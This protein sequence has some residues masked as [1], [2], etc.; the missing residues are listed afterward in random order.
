M[1][2]FLLIVS[3][4]IFFAGVFLTAVG[5]TKTEE[6]ADSTA[7]KNHSVLL[8]KTDQKDFLK[9]EVVADRGKVTDS[10][11]LYLPDYASRDSF[12]CDEKIWC[13][14]LKFLEQPYNR[15]VVIRDNNARIEEYEIPDNWVASSFASGRYIIYSTEFQNITIKRLDLETGELY[16]YGNDEKQG[17]YPNVELCRPVAE[18]SLTRF[19]YEEKWFDVF[20]DEIRVSQ[21]Q[22]SPYL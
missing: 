3:A 12:F 21:I 13:L 15:F 9:L 1:K 20:E 10:K 4:G 8:K 14:K 7:L 17:W 5:C 16:E 18:N 11:V 22:E 6:I 2:K 19:C